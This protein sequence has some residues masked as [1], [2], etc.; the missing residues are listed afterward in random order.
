[1]LALVP[2]LVAVSATGAASAAEPATW[3]ENTDVNPWHAILVYVVI[4]L[5]LFAVITL[6]ALLPTMGKSQSYHP[7]E[8]WRGEPEWF[9]GPR[10]GV[11]TLEAGTPVDAGSNQAGGSHRGGA[12]GSW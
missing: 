4:P 5:A 10:G 3:T 9:G 12:S 2:A 11:H 7:G 8:A 1:V 6:L